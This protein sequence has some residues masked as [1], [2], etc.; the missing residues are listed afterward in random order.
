MNPWGGLLTFR[1][2]DLRA[3]SYHSQ[4]PERAENRIPSRF[5]GPLP[6]RVGLGVLR[7]TAALCLAMCAPLFAHDEPHEQIERISREIERYPTD[8]ELYMARGGLHRMTGHWEA[9]LADFDRV[10]ALDPLHPTIDFHR[11]RLLLEVGQYQEARDLLDRFLAEH[12]THAQGLMVRARSLLRLGQPLLAAR[13]Y[14]QALAQMAKPAPVFYLERADALAAAGDEHLAAAI[15][16][17]DEGI[18]RLGPLILLQSKAIDLEVRAQHY[19]AAL[20]RIDQI[21]SGMPRKERWLARRGEVFELAG[22]EDEARASYAEALAAIDDLPSHLGQTP[23]VQELAA[24]LKRRL[25]G[26]PGGSEGAGTRH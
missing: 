4:C 6:M 14:S 2:V 20:A 3:I 21:L 10:I 25:E 9:A 15:D 12:P 11:G 16:S 8:V 17:L 19:D 23:A 24:D 7:L 26:D 5:P 1:W 22:W 18:A 13:D